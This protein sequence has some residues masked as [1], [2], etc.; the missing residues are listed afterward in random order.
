MQ[1]RISCIICILSIGKRLPLMLL[2]KGVPDDT[3]ENR[4][5]KLPEVKTNRIYIACQKK[6]MG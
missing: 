4:L 6:F 3:L 5:N 2:F 1:Q